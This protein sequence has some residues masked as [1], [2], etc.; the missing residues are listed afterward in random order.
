MDGTRDVTPEA[1]L[2]SGNEVLGPMLT[3]A[4]FELGPTSLGHGSGGEFGV[5][6]WMR[7][8]QSIELH[9]RF[10][11]GIVRYAWGDEAFDHAHIVGAL[12]VATSFPGFSNE[13]IDNFRR[14]AADLAGPLAP[15]LGRTSEIVLASARAWTPPGRWLP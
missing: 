2:A 8:A 13:P 9:V 1:L 14:L 5:C 12:G 11:L 7:E 3:T 6:R 4:G 10:A 15:V